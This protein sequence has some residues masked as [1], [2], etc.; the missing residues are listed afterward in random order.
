MCQKVPKCPWMRLPT[1]MP[2]PV[3]WAL[4]ARGYT[5]SLLHLLGSL[6][7]HVCPHVDILGCN[8][9]TREGTWCWRSSAGVCTC[10]CGWARQG[11]V[12]VL[13]FSAGVAMSAPHTHIFAT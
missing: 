10:P 6:C 8:C 2:V 1:S 4:L 3:P 9:V 13:P 5:S 12:H 7:A 11:C